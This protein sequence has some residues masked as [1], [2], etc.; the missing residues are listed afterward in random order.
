MFKWKIL[1]VFFDLIDE[2]FQSLRNKI[3]EKDR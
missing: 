2:L 3:E 1:I